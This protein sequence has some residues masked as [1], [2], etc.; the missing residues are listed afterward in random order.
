MTRVSLRRLALAWAGIATLAWTASAALSAGCV[1]PTEGDSSADSE[2]TAESLPPTTC[3]PGA[4]APCYTGPAGTEGVGVCRGGQRTCDA[5]G[6]G[7]GPCLGEVRPAP[8]RC[9]T[10][11]DEDCDG[12]G[13]ERDRD[14][15][16]APGEVRAC[17]TGDPATRGVGMCHDGTSTCDPLTLTWSD[18]CDG[19]TLPAP[20]VC[21]TNIDDEDCNGA[22][23]GGDVVWAL[24][25]GGDGPQTAHAI[26]TDADGNTVVV[27]SFRGAFT[28][29]G[30]TYQNQGDLDAA[31]IKI[32]PDGTVRWV[33]PIGPARSQ[34]VR[35]V[36]IDAH[37]DI[38]IA[39]DFEHTLTFPSPGQ[40]APP[41]SLVSTSASDVDL[42]VAKLDP[43]GKLLWAH[44]YG[45]ADEQRAF[46]LTV[47]AQGDVLV[48]GAMAGKIDF[49]GTVFTSAG[50]RD[51]FVA[52]WSADGE[53]GWF[54]RFGTLH[55]QEGTDLALGAS[56]LVTGGATGAF[57]FGDSVI[58]TGNSADVL[59]LAL[60]PQSGTPRW[61]VSFGHPG[62]TQHQVG[63]GIALDPIGHPL[64]TGTFTDAL[65][66]G[67]TLLHGG[68]TSGFVAK[69]SPTGQPLWSRAFGS[70]TSQGN[71]IASDRHGNVLLAGHFAGSADLDDPPLHAT[72][73]GPDL[74][75]AK[76]DPEGRLLW[77]R[78]L[79]NGSP[80][81]GT[82]ITT[83]ASDAILLAGQARG[84]LD[85][86]PQLLNAGPHPTLF[87][88]KLHP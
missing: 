8:E 11:D 54:K 68:T 84:T 52:S 44:D 55:H 28:L 59:A 29:A 77:S 17:Y 24:R 38:Y 65:H 4:T 20:E 23:C 47:G 46:G 2:P 50:G 19:Q 32:D 56:L 78:H 70:T 13:G 16:C 63:L 45:D 66:Q 69:L 15:V 14:C 26:A 18:A 30:T 83:D 61:G 41:V 7:Y 72:Q 64:L 10:P 22:L 79:G 80:Q 42:F 62:D 1:L 48:T 36:S 6:A 88:T 25:A 5:R 86:G 33:L 81:A 60:D 87:V 39:G 37:G 27:A 53:P 40:G 12:E 82:A 35:A 51:L 57:P 58:S 75:V 43:Q 3:I 34:I 9:S 67:D 31:V 76:L 74:L 71:A 85:L 49:G 73:P 21:T